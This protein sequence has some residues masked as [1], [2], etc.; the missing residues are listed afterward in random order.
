[1]G[2]KRP[3]LHLHTRNSNTR[4]PPCSFGHGTPQ[5][6]LGFAITTAG[7]VAFHSHSDTR[8][9]LR[10]D[11]GSLSRDTLVRL[12]SE[13]ERLPLMERLAVQ[14]LRFAPGCRTVTAFVG[15]VQISEIK[16]TGGITYSTPPDE[17]QSLFYV[18]PGPIIEQG[19]YN[20]GTVRQA[21]I[22]ITTR[23]V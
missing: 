1:M 7:S 3:E 16:N 5:I 10:Q 18:Q 12:C 9:S 14:T 19:A 2:E 23:W 8:E 11:G 22:C 4:P 20:E 6:Y 13:D 17:F 15:L 21:Q